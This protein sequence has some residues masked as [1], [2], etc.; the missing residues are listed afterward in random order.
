MK[1]ENRLI[2]D[3]FDECRKLYFAKSKR[4]K[5]TNKSAAKLLC[6]AA[7]IFMQFFLFCIFR[8]ADILR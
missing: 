3:V 5:I 1:S 7:V 4:I 6:F 2:I 8:R